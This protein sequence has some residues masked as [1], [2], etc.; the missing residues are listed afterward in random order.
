M[1]S[2]TSIH[3]SEFLHFQQESRQNEQERMRFSKRGHSPLNTDNKIKTQSIESSFIAKNI[4]QLS[5]THIISKSLD[6]VD[7]L[8]TGAMP[9]VMIGGT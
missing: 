3:L 2:K 5:S 8:I 4:R 6:D 1:C 9:R 7:V